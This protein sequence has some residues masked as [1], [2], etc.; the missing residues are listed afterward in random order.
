MIPDDLLYTDTH[1]WVRFENGEAEIGITHFAQEQ[2]GD[3]TCIALPAVGAALTEGQE[4]GTVESVKAASELYAP[5]NCTVLAV[6]ADL[7]GSPE[8]VNEAP[9]GAG[10]MLRV[11]VADEHPNLLTPDQ[12][13]KLVEASAH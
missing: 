5:I 10:W 1:E 4:I 7:E 11:A 3:L 13:R 6:N 12:Y 9:Y 2:L 8:L